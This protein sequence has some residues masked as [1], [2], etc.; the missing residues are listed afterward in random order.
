VKNAKADF[1]TALMHHDVTHFTF[2]C[3]GNDLIIVLGT[4]LS[5]DNKT[6]LQEIASCVEVEKAS[7]VYLCTMEEKELREQTTFFSRYEAGSEEGVLA[8]LTKAFL[9]NT[10]LPN[11]L[12]VYFENLDDGYLS[13]ESNIGE[14]EI[15]EIQSLYEQ[16]ARVVI[17]LGDDLYNHPRAKN[18][19]RLAGLFASYGK[20]KILLSH[21]ED[22]EITDTKEIIPEEVESLKSFDGVVVYR[23]PAHD[24]EEEG[25]LVGSLQ[26]QMAA[27][28]QHGEKIQVAINQA[29][30]PRTF[31]LDES[32][33]GTIALMPCAKNE[34]ISYRYSVAKIVK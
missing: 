13:A 7:L 4:L 11:D 2:T 10:V 14:E 27:K 29:M 3:K 21:T 22:L 6:M 24:K 16:S 15:E 32:L 28:V 8:L 18:I 19:A 5:R 30:Y 12:Q 23:C 1:I 34:D 33:K 9:A 26:F 25:N 17:V 31:V 20:A